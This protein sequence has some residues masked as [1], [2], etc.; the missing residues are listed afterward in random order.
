MANAKLF[1]IMIILLLSVILLV[2]CDMTTSSESTAKLESQDIIPVTLPPGGQMLLETE[3]SILFMGARIQHVPTRRVTLFDKT[4]RQEV[5]RTFTKGTAIR[6]ILLANGDFIVVTTAEKQPARLLRLKGDTGEVVWERLF[7]HPAL[8]ALWFDDAIGLLVSDGVSLWRI[9]PA[10]GTPIATLA[11]SLGEQATPESVYLATPINGAGHLY[12]ASDR[13]L[14]ALTVNAHQ[15]QKEWK[16]RSA[17]FIAE[18]LPLHFR[19]GPMGVLVFSHSHVY[20]VD[21]AGKSRWHFKNTDINYGAI[22]LPNAADAEWIVFGNYVKG[23]YVADAQGVRVH[24]PLPEGN[25]RVLGIPLPI[26]KHVL[27]GGVTARPVSEDLAG[28]YWMA[29]RSLDALFLYRFIPP[30][31]LTWIAKAPVGRD[32]KDDSMVQKANIRP[33]YPPF[34][35]GKDLA[36]TTPQGIVLFQPPDP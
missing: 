36:L 8:D 10:D 18:L 28:G 20:F 19:N 12:L 9:E 22:A 24:V 32:A 3:H 5:W 25:M 11:T 6:A 13:L 27:L 2:A 31:N 21:E 15:T 26:P 17:K 30:E 7:Q 4:T 1:F 29:V 23:L 33:N 34:W 14:I 35:L 16:F